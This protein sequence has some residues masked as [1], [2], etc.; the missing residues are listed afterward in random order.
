MAE[1]LNKLSAAAVSAAVSE[2]DLIEGIKRS[3]S[4]ATQAGVSFNELVGGYNRRPR[5]D[6]ARGSGYW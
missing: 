6:C 3:G 1:V 4:V 5:K 2:K